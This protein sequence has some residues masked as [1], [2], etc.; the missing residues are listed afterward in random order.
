M[1]GIIEFS[2]ILLSGVPASQYYESKKILLWLSLSI[3]PVNSVCAAH[4]NNKLF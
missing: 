2:L 3:I 4:S 1:H